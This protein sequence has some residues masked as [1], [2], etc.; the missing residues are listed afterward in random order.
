MRTEKTVMKHLLIAV[1]MI[2]LTGVVLTGCGLRNAD[3]ENKP[4]NFV[5]NDSTK[6]KSGE[7]MF[8]VQKTDEE[9]KKELTEEQYYVL[10]QKGTERA[11]TGEYDHHKEKGVFACAGCGAELF[12]SEMKYDSGCGWP[13]FFT[14]LAGDRIIE[15]VDRSFGMIRTEILCASCGGHLGHVFDDGPQPTGLRYCVNSASLKFIR[16][17]QK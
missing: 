5:T 2:T 8:K 6:E 1:F 7:Y 4:E 12:S 13:A 10:R 14:K 16:S 15:Q 3:A 11:F 17:G 9:W